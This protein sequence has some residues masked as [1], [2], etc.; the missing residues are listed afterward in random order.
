MSARGLK[1]LLMAITLLA[2]SF[3]FGWLRWETL[4]FSGD[5]FPVSAICTGTATPKLDQ[6][7]K[8]RIR[9]AMVRREDL[10]M[11]KLKVEGSWVL[12]VG[13]RGIYIGFH[14]C[15]SMEN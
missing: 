2:D 14:V 5:A 4:I 3:G 12:G 7:A 10:A 11:V 9:D 15:V 6:I 13:L 1:V 8:I